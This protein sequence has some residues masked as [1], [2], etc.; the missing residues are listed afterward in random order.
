MTYQPNFNDPRVIKRCQQALG[1]ACGVMSETKSHSWST[2]YIDKYFGM[3]SNPL[4]IYLRNTLLI[5]TNDS[6]RYNSGDKNKCKEYILNKEGVRSL[7]EN[8]K[9]TIYNTYPSVLQVANSD[10]LEELNTG[11][12]TYKDQSNRLWHPLQRYRREYRT[13]ILADQNYTHDYDI[14]CCAPTLIHQYAQQLGM[15]EYLFALRRYL[16]DRTSVRNQ[17]AIELELESAAVKEIINA[18]FCGATISANKDHSD[19]YKILNGDLVRI[20]YLKQNK[21]LIELIMDI[22]TC[23]AY[24]TPHMSRRRNSTTNR[25]IKITCRQK[26]NVY[27]EL[28]RQIIDQVRVY[29]NDKSNKHFLIHDG[30]TCE[31]EV[32]RDD[33]RD[34]LRDKTGYEINFDYTKF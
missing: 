12:F 23:W 5:V 26:W 8:L 6:Y 11:N 27:F 33:L 3:C 4:S 29:L 2:R 28:E 25:L 9:L 10:H 21:F 18:L 19:I 15:D 14:E 32:D 22:K 30:W 16:T 1:F 17:L 34:Y 31:R 24:I 7:R 20:E 13:Q